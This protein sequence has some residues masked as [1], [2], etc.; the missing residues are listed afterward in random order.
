MVDDTRDG[1]VKEL[2]EPPWWY[3]CE[4]DLTDFA[5][6]CA[7]HRGDDGGGRTKCV[8]EMG[9]GDGGT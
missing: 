2:N 1:R 5:M 4:C 7:I 3:L 9:R 8:N 6:R